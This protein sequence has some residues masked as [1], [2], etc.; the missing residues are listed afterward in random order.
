MVPLHVPSIRG[1]GKITAKPFL[2]ALIFGSRRFAFA[3]LV[4]TVF[5]PPVTPFVLPSI[6]PES[7]LALLRR[8][9]P[10]FLA[11]QA[12]RLPRVAV[13]RSGRMRFPLQAPARSASTL[14][15]LRRRM[16][17]AVGSATAKA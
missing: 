15:R 12:C 16:M 1:G 8:S 4:A 17:M 7:T 14:F 5:F 9:P 3:A 11:E 13:G 6:F 10:F 2:T